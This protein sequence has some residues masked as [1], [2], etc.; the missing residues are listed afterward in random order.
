M[1]YASYAASGTAPARARASDNRASIVKV[2][3]EL[4]LRQTAHP[5]RGQPEP[6]LQ[7]PEARSTAAP[8]R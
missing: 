2:S 7:R 5:K 3:V 6:V 8:R 4:N 1:E